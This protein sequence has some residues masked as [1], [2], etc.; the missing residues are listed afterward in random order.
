[1]DQVKI[2][3]ESLCTLGEGP[4]WHPQRKTLI[5]FDIMGKNLLERSLDSTKAKKFTFDNYVSAAGWINQNELLMATSRS[6]EKVN[7][8]TGDLVKIVDLEADNQLTRSNDGRADPYGGFWIGTMGIK[9]EREQ[10]AIYRF[11]KGELRKMFS[12]ISIPNSICFSPCGKIGYFTDTVPGIIL[13]VDLDTVGWP[14]SEPEIFIDCRKDGINPDGSVIDS[15]GCIWN[16][17][18]G[19]SRV[20]RYA[21]DGE[22]LK[23]I[24]FAAPQASCP[25]FGGDQLSTLFVTSARDGMTESQLKSAPLSGSLFSVETEFLGQREHKVL[26]T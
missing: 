25:E 4:L 5:W 1:M 14:K 9:M 10:G 20:A 21:P 22:L 15:E 2:F 3:D 17:Q 23:T 19:S 6:L 8:N 12:S 24:E 13:R 7:I 18:W 11:Y 16:A 26:L